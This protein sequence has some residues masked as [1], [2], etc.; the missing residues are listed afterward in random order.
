MSE[1]YKNCYIKIVGGSEEG[2]KTIIIKLWISRLSI[3]SFA[4]FEPLKNKTKNF[5]MNCNIYK[6]K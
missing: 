1:L 2:R 3:T 6:T 5:T 4:V